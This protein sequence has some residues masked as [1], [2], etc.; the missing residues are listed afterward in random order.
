MKQQM[1]YE[2]EQKR[3]EAER[4]QQQQQ[5]QS[6]QQQQ[7]QSLQNSSYMSTHHSTTDEQHLL[8]QSMTVNTKEAMSAVQDLWQSPS[9]STSRIMSSPI[10]HKMPDA[11]GKISFDIHM[12]SSM[13]QNVVVSNKVH[14]QQQQQQNF[15]PV[16]PYNDQE[17]RHFHNSYSNQEH[18]NSYGNHSM[19]Q[20]SYHYSM[21]VSCKLTISTHNLYNIIEYDVSHINYKFQ[22][23]VCKHV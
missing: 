6:P 1:M 2:A 16:Q 9:N 13:T 15:G 11:R 17:N 5:Q 3:L 8:G 23:S 18:Q 12:D 22:V 14:H 7:Q 20:N 21:Q 4:L 10:A 19:V